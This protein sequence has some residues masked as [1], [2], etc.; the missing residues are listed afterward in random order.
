[1]ARILDFSLALN[2]YKEK[3]NQLALYKVNKTSTY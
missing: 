1:M 3:G 2:K